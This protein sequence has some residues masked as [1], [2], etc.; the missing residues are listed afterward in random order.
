MYCGFRP[1]R[2]IYP[3]S[4]SK[5]SPTGYA[6][7]GGP[8][9]EAS[10]DDT[11]VGDADIL[12]EE[13]Q[14]ELGGYDDQHVLEHIAVSAGESH[15]RLAAIE[16][17]TSQTALVGC[18]LNDAV[19]ANRRAAVERLDDRRALE[20]VAQ[21]IGKKDKNV[22]RIVRRKLKEIAEREAMLNR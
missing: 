6:S 5:F 18:A 14:A 15:V 1:A 9:S 12:S 8:G 10:S 20:Q 11:F 19:A 3:A 7:L 22:R 16:R 2:T 21:Q 17:L 13:R 4:Q